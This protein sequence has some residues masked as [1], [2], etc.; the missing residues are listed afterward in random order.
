MNKKKIAII[1]NVIPHYRK[2]FYDRLLKKSNYEITVYC[3]PKIPN[4][5]LKTIHLNYLNHI[6]LLKSYFFLKE[7]F[8]YTLLPWRKI[9]NDYDLV[10][11]EANPRYI[12]Y[13]LISVLR[14]LFKKKVA[15]WT[16]LFSQKNNNFLQK[17]R[18]FWMS[19]YDKFLVYSEKDIYYLKKFTPSNSLIISINNGLNQNDIEQNIS[20]WTKNKLNKW[21][22]TK[23]VNG[24]IILLSCARIESKNNFREVLLALPEI[25]KVYPNVI[26]C[27][28]GSG[29]ELSYLRALTHKLKLNNY[30]NFLGAIH[31]EKNLA[32]W[33]LSSQLLIH[34]GSIGLTLFHSLGYGLPVVT[35][36]N[37]R[38]H[39]PEF[40][41]FKDKNSRFCFTENNFR[42][43]RDLI[44][45]L[46]KNND[47]NKN[48][49]ERSRLF[50]KNRYNTS[51]M[52]DRFIRFLNLALKG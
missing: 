12:S 52:A 17:L 44:I 49:G 10:I 2:D 36:S 28:I 26:W 29:S 25:I 50:I 41:A 27:V 34:P 24:R 51:V 11:V 32:P 37:W 39:A 13:F 6:R 7:Y 42:E 3:N 33:F 21:K 20:F 31:D 14:R 35:H 43:M 38:A 18:F 47:L 30:V 8:I 23:G 16:M 4:S 40:L 22:D 15:L 45:Q 1:V 46:I 5:S 9:L 19:F 48:F